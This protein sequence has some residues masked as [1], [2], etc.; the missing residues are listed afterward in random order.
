[1]S[2][3]QNKYGLL[4]W[5]IIRYDVP[6]LNV[7][8]SQRFDLRIVR[9]CLILCTLQQHLIDRN[10]K[11]LITTAYENAQQLAFYNTM[12]CMTFLSATCCTNRVHRPRTWNHSM[13]NRCTIVST[14]CKNCDNNNVQLQ[15]EPTHCTS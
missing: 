4:I 5:A 15:L 2:I 9:F 14:C 3:Y 1:M 11:M 8:L 12:I 7:A 10:L 6:P 13:S